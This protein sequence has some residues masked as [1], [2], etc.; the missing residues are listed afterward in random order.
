M[1]VSVLGIDPG[2]TRCGYGLVR[3]GPNR[4]LEFSRAGIFATSP[5]EKISDRL[6]EMHKDI[7][8]LIEEISPDEI[9]IERVFFQSNVSTAMSVAQV[10]GLVHSI[11][12]SRSIPVFEYSPTQ[13][14]SS[15]TGDGKADKIQVQT[16]VTKLLGLKKVPK[17]ADAADALA[18]AMTHLGSIKTKKDDDSAIYNGSNLHNAI[19]DA[20]IRQSKPSADPKRRYKPQ[21]LT[22]KRPGMVR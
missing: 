14:K 11:A 10:S 4:A 20:I 7:A 16:M 9:A 21:T 12:A 17:P 19:A 1:F 6:A 18:I 2:L 3:Q 22:K 8:A 15:I 5:Q 13:V